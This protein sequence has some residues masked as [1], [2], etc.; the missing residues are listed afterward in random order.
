[1]I[2]SPIA[3]RN[4]ARGALGFGSDVMPRLVRNSRDVKTVGL[5]LSRNF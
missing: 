2:E 1:M 5:S 3:D 4:D